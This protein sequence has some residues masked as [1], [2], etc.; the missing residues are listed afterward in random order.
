MRALLLCALA[1]GC[2]AGSSSSYFDNTGRPDVGS[3]GVRRIAIDTP[4]GKFHVWTKRVGNNPSLKVLTLH[5]G[6][7]ATHEYF[8]IFDTH[9]PAAGIE[10]YYYDQLG[11]VYS[12]QPGSPAPRPLQRLADHG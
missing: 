2:A 8:E 4:N 5:G 7:A 6:P 1:T 11:S 10:Y 3:G 12:A 9:L